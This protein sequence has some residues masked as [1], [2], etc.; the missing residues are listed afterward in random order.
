M[1]KI[2]SIAFAAV[3]ALSV[4]AAMPAKHQAPVTKVSKATRAYA[5]VHKIESATLSS[6]ALKSV[7]KADEAPALAD[8]TG[9]Y[10]ISYIDEINQLQ[11]EGETT[12]KAGAA[13][14]EVLI[15]IPFDFSSYY[16]GTTTVDI[17]ATYAD[18][19]LTFTPGATLTMSLLGED[20]TDPMCLFHWNDDYQ[21]L[22]EVTSFTAQWNGKGFTFNPDDLIAMGNPYSDES[23]WF[24]IDEITI[25]TDPTLDPNYNPNEGWTS[26]GEADFTDGWVLPAFDADQTQNV[27]KVELQQNDA[28][29]NLYRLVDPYHGN[30]PMIDKNECTKAGYI[31]FNVS[32]PDHVVFEA[33]E[34]GFA[35][36]ELGITK[37]YCINGLAIY[38]DYFN[39]ELGNNLTNDEIIEMLG[40]NSIYTTF[41]DGVVT[42]GSFEHPTFGTVYDACF[43]I[44]GEKHG[45]YGWT[46]ANSASKNMH[47][48]IVFP[49]DDS[50]INSVAA[51]AAN[52][53]V[54]YFNLQGVRVARP[55]AGQV[56][57]RRQGADATKVVF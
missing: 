45:G 5:P 23:A 9:D 26:M 42:L 32:D 16:Y 10:L 43:G 35:N 52:I 20:V 28:D 13:E 39:N 30:F 54:E 37:M 19:K 40:E 4:S 2:Y 44:Q 18:G 25:E 3:C 46:D 53:P 17:P 47:A 12:I 21:G 1:K 34:A 27:Y 49:S 15:T 51:D 55:A 14:G 38:I 6:H 31:Q 29:K 7:A 56:V 36:S 24:G 57:I 33:V 41:K 11:Y 8:I 48:R 50:A 22:H